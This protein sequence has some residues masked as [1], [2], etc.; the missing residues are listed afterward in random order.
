MKKAIGII[1]SSL[2]V[3]G[4][5]AEMDC[6]LDSSYHI[7]TRTML[8]DGNPNPTY[9]QEITT[10][11]C[12][13]L[14][15]VDGVQVNGNEVTFTIR[16]VDHEPIR[17]IEL[18]IYHDA[19]DLEFSGYAKGSK[20][21]NV[22]DE[23]G[24]PRTMTLLTNY[25]EDH[26]K[27]L[28]YSTSRARTEGNGEEGDLCHITYTLAEGASLPEQVTFYFGLANVPGTSMDPE[29][30]NVV[31][32]YPDENNPAVVSTATVAADAGQVIPDAFALNQNYPNPFNPSTQISIDV[33]SGSEFITLTIYNLLGQNVKTLVNKVL[34]P[35]QYT[36]EW[37]AIDAMGF[38]AASG[39][40]F[41]ELRSESF[42]ARKKMLLIR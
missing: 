1:I 6:S 32:G 13:C 37:D 7:D 40:Y 12:A 22:T 36:F 25:L 20:L 10:G 28:A 19:A 16:I 9:G 17:G 31:C 27:V 34:S 21:E 3:S 24:T 2:L 35:G 23:E 29:L 30:L 14:G 18:D 38:P 42:I 26:L 39:I 8:P 4:V 11:L 33:P 5:W 15:H 41:Y